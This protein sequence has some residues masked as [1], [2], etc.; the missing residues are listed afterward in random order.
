MRA[1]AP[2]T[3]QVEIIEVNG[4]LTAGDVRPGVIFSKQVPPA[5]PVSSDF[6]DHLKEVGASETLINAALEAAE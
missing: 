1:A 4:S 6:V 2:I 3:P 5:G